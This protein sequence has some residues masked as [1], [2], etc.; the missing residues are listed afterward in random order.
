LI[1]QAKNE[2]ENGKIS[3]RNARKDANNSLT[4]LKKDGVSE[5]SVKRGEDQIQAMTDKFTTKIDDLLVAKEKDIMT[6]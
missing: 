2:I 3:V 4:K 5:D 6:V 1:K